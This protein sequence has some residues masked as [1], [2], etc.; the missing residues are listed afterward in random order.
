MQPLTR[1]VGIP[2]T[3]FMALLA[4][5]ACQSVSDVTRERVSAAD[6]AVQQA[7][8]SVGTQESAAVELQHA[9]DSLEQAKRELSKKNGQSAE[10]WAR[11]A[12]LDAELAIAKSQS[13]AS[14]KAADEL[15]ASIEQLRRE[16]QRA[17]AGSSETR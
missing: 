2:S 13:A 11:A 4:L 17:P 6:A 8:Q 7:Q 5:T 3:A 15:L 10:R 1:Y 12:Q 14:R 9:K 16:S